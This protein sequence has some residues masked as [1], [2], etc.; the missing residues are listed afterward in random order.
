MFHIAYVPDSSGVSVLYTLDGRKPEMMKRPGFGDSTLKYTGPILLPAGKVSVRAMAVS[1]C[2]HLCYVVYNR[3]G[4][5][6]SVTGIIMSKG[7]IF[8]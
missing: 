2:V 8:L 4:V 5:F 6:F 7:L 1:T 3:L